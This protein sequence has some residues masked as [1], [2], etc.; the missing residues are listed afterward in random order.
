MEMSEDIFF[1]ISGPGNC[2]QCLDIFL[3]FFF[4]SR[5]GGSRVCKNGEWLLVHTGI[6]FI[7]DTV[8]LKLVY[9]YSYTILWIY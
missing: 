6:F 9:G 5:A 2:F 4:L 3:P 7:G 1:G 8:A